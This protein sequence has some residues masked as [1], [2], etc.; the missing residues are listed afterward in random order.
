MSETH[1]ATR[2]YTVTFAVLLI[3]L[4][5]TVG[6]SYLNLGWFN[7]FIAVGIAATKMTLIAMFFMH[8]RSARR[9]TL[10]VVFAGLF[11]LGILFTLGLSDYLTRWSLPSPDVWTGQP[12]P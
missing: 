1:D 10:V 6:V 8:A 3:L 5:V 7:A 12:R 11:W 4:G 2:E 9:M